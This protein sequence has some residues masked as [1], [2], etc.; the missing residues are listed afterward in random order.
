[1][2]DLT[3]LIRREC[4]RFLA[5]WARPRHLLV[6]SYDPKTHSVKGTFQPEGHMSGWI[7]I[8]SQGASVGGISV[9]VGPSIGDLALVSYVEGDPEVGCVIGFK[10]NDVDQPPGAE[11]GTAVIKHNPS[12]VTIT[13]NGS[14][15]VINSAAMP[16]TVQGQTIN[17]TA[18]NIVVTGAMA[19]TGGSTFS[20]GGNLA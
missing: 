3:N 9:Q 5:R 4:A 13:L 19:S 15:I 6:T 17:L 16:M 8:V 18:P 14:G 12:G 1:M 20:G 2:I 10:H 7:P 11:S